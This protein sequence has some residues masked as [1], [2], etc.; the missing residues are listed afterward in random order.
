MLGENAVRRRA[1][2]LSNRVE[3]IFE[4]FEFDGITTHGDLSEGCSVLDGSIVEPGSDERR[5]AKIVL[6]WL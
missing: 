3:K 1:H 5:N 4:D 2:L 6:T